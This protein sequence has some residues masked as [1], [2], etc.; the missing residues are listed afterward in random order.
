M[1]IEEYREQQRRALNIIWTTAEDYSFRPVFMAFDREG[2]ADLYLNS[3]IG[4]AHK[5]YKGRELEELPGFFE[6]A[7]LQD[8]YDTVYWLCLENCVY[9]KEYPERPVIRELRR[10]YAF[11]VMEEDKFG[12]A[13]NGGQN[14]EGE[15][16]G[17]SLAFTLKRAH[18]GNVLGMAPYLL[19]WERKLFQAM[20]LKADMTEK[21]LAEEIKNILWTYFHFRCTP[22]TDN[23][24]KKNK[25]IFP[26]LSLKKRGIR[27]M[28]TRLE[29][30]D[31]PPSV[32]E[33]EEGKEEQDQDKEKERSPRQEGI[34]GWFAGLLEE[35]SEA[36][37]D[38]WAREYIELTFGKPIWSE[39]ER[40]SAEALLCTGN[41]RD[42]HLYFTRGE[43]REL[44]GE[45]KAGNRTKGEAL[46]RRKLATAQEQKNL[47]YYEAH[48]DAFRSCILR[49]K[50]QIS[51]A[52]L[53]RQ[54]PESVRSKIGKLE[55][56]QIW[57]QLYLNDNRVFTKELWE[58]QAPFSVDIMLDGSA[59]QIHHQEMTASQGYI[60]AESLRLCGIPVQVYSFLSFHGYTVF[61]LLREYGDREGNRN[62]FRYYAC[63]WNRDGLALR[64]A[65]YLMKDSPCPHRLLIILTDAS[66]ND[67]KKMPAGEHSFRRQEYER[68]AGIEDAAQEVRRLKQKGIRVVG[69][70]YGPDRDLE[71]ARAIYGSSF[72]RIRDAGQLADTVGGL[73]CEEVR[74]MA[75]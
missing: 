17:V 40:Q 44:T 15:D 18:F 10:Q 51:N 29:P 28:V 13:G 20:K 43:S 75:E 74:Q 4:W 48:Q 22:K 5:W 55:G 25:G 38:E 9:Q 11:G 7:A 41:H 32:H 31:N 46:D 66:P 47:E 59:S 56:K 62:L 60:I 24:G 54:E 23:K 6:G 1:E 49:L 57:R 37:R 2:R 65:G 26:R 14:L 61:R 19:P 72:A 64:G 3:V 35:L 16:W 8:V 70:F 27:L 67:D 69:V 30:N 36:G 42:C 12:K 58:E 53:I 21:E 34:R 50:E 63:G 39:R 71:G 68:R 52:F 73:I 33:A 45:G